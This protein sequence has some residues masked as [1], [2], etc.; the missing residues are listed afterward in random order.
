MDDNKSKLKQIRTYLKKIN[1]EQV[2]FKSP[3]PNPLPEGEGT[4]AGEG[5]D[6]RAHLSTMLL[7]TGH[8]GYGEYE[9]D[10]SR[11][12][13]SRLTT[14]FASRSS[15]RATAGGTIEIDNTFK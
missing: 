7:R 1:L 9:Y 5:G 3:H 15:A 10:H 13:R 4:E 11:Y 14:H 12:G 2:F 6:E 8:L